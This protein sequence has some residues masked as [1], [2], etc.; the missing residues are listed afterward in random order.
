MMPNVVVLGG[1]A[2]GTLA[3]N[4]LRRRF[5]TGRLAITVV[6]QD[7]RH[8]SQPGLLFVPFGLTQVEDI[9][10]SRHRTWPRGSAA[11]RV[12]PR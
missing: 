1:G 10:R 7:D 5:D 9:V 4:R 11:F 12:C 2:G 3:A 8:V 6:D